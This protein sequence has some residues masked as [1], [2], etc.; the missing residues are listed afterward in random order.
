MNE[1]QIYEYL[2]KGQINVGESNETI[3][4]EVK[5]TP[6]TNLIIKMKN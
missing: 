6:G 4:K 1:K 5:H 3:Y 2:I